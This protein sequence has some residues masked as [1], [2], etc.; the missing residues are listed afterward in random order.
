LVRVTNRSINTVEALLR[1][2][3]AGYFPMGDNESGGGPVRWYNP[4]PRGVMPLDDGFHVPRRLAERVRSGAFDVT[5]AR[6]L[7]AVCGAWGA[8]RPPPGEQKSWIDERIIGAYTALHLAGH[9]HSIEAW[10]PGPGGPEL[11]GGLYGVHIGAAFFAES[12]FYRPGKGTDASKVCLVRMVDHLRARG[13]ELLDVQFWNPHIA[14]FGCVEIPRAEY[15]DRLKRATAR[16]VEWLP[17]EGS[18]DD[19]AAG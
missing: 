13:F 8:P 11:A 3:R 14:Q 2:Y 16:E 4:D 7:A 19:R 18:T 6:G 17:F 15:L 12:K 10:V 1:A 9:A 5:P